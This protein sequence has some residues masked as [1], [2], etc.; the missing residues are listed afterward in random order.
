[1]SRTAIAWAAAAA[2]GLVALLG[3]AYWLGTRA[4]EPGGPGVHAR[5][6]ATVVLAVRELSRLEGATAHVEKVI[7]LT[8]AQQRLF[9][10]LDAKD[11]IL[12]V[13]VGDVVAGADL[14]RLSEGDVQVDAATGAVRV[15]LPAPEVFSAA[16]DETQTH[17]Y[18]RR[19]DVLASRNEQLEGLARQDAEKQM[20]AAAVDQGLL[21]RA[22]ASIERTLRSL[23]HSL[24]FA[25]VDIEWRAGAR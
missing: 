19:T 2:L 24:G 6:T 4:P 17:V 15:T 20:R 1:M 13:A 9:G 12:L 10:L 18:E 11:A 21:E 8:D 5:S 23:L 7:E 14:S 3:G 22:R 25:R 16:L